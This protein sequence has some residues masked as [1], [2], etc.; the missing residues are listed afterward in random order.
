M[1]LSAKSTCAHLCKVKGGLFVKCS[2]L[3]NHG[4]N[5]R[6]K[7]TEW[8]T[9]AKEDFLL[10]KQRPSKIPSKRKGGGLH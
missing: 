4:G 5:H 1:A 7:E 10:E 2:K 8:V 3:L 6:Y 9:F